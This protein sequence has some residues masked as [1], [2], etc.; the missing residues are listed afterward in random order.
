MAK[1]K[2]KHIF[3]IE[4]RSCGDYRISDEAF[5][6]YD[7][8]ANFILRRSDR[9]QKVTAYH[10]ESDSCDYIIHDLTIRERVSV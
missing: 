10:F 6:S 7:D 4:V 5:G 8:A 2:V 9:P 3:T 1:V